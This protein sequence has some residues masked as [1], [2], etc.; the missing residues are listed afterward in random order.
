MDGKRGYEVIEEINLPRHRSRWHRFLQRA[1]YPSA[2]A[3]DDPDRFDQAVARMAKIV[4]D[5]NPGMLRILDLGAGHCLL[6][7]GLLKNHSCS[8]TRSPKIEYVA[9]D[10][11]LAREDQRWRDVRS[12]AISKPCG[13]FLEPQ[14]Y[15]FNFVQ[16][17]MFQD[18]LA[19]HYPF[20]L[21]YML[22]VFHEL[23]PLRITDLLKLLGDSLD[24]HGQIMLLD[25]EADWAIKEA[26]DSSKFLSDCEWEA[27]STW[28]ER[29]GV[30]RLLEEVG[31]QADGDIYERQSM[32]LWVAYGKKAGGGEKVPPAEV[33]QV[34]FELQKQRVESELQQYQ[35][36]R[37]ELKKAL[38]PMKEQDEENIRFQ[39][40]RLA[41]LCGTVCRRLETLRQLEE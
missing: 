28:Y 20:N 11:A 34:L 23:D 39:A 27:Y 31:F 41:A 2:S 17:D 4:H 37:D 10:K 29:A 16:A 25:P 5:S 14:L 38:D 18:V 3:K 15:T 19:K 8:K 40:M 13:C 12:S 35:E 24:T 1:F 7:E 21:I 9:V 22:N 26:W 32:R 33:T 6:L 30:I 36:W